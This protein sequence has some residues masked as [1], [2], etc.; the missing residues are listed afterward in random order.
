METGTKPAHVSIVRR[1]PL[2][3]FHYAGLLP[4]SPICKITGTER[5]RFSD[6]FSFL[7]SLKRVDILYRGRKLSQACPGW[8]RKLAAEHGSQ[9]ISRRPVVISEQ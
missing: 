7:T 8:L 9:I 5:K 6:Q 3:R 2:E 4:R 1:E